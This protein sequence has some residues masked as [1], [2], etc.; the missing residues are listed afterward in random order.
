M[1]EIL[2]LDFDIPIWRL[3]YDNSSYKIPYEFEYNN[4]E[5]KNGITIIQFGWDPIV[6]ISKLKNDLDRFINPIL[7]VPDIEIKKIL[8]KN[9][10]CPVILASHNAFINENI[11]NINNN[12]EKKYDLVINSCFEN[13]KRRHLANKIDN[14][15]HIG[16]FQSDNGYIPSNGICPNFKNNIRSKDNYER[17]TNDECINYYNQS[18]IGG[19]FS[20]VEGSCFSSG[21]YLLCGLPVLSTK[22][23]GGRQHWYNEK[24]SII[25]NP[26]ENDIYNGYLLA[27]KK[28]KNGEFNPDE[29]RQMHLDEMDIHR[30]N[31]TLAVLEIMKKI[32]NNIPKFNDLKESLKYYHSNIYS[33]NNIYTFEQK[34]NKENLIA[35]EI[36]DKYN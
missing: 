8:E 30:N 18:K 29:I 24:N 13:Y 3:F 27:F 14:V 34:Q 20:E 17:L 4:K 1:K 31:L 16:Y 10:T 26:N 5:Y 7:C 35:K 6:F 36:L 19:I 12:I 21:E 11:Y 22:C 9:F 32:T 28:L 25:C 15:I 33:G 2:N 23:S